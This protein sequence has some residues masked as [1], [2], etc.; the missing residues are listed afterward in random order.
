MRGRERR[1]GIGA[2]GFGWDRLI[3]FFRSRRGR[4]QISRDG[5]LPPFVIS[6]VVLLLLL[7]CLYSLLRLLFFRSLNGSGLSVPCCLVSLISRRRRMICVLV[8]FVLFP[9]VI[10]SAHLCRSLGHR[11]FPIYH[12]LPHINYCL[13]GVESRE[14]ARPGCQGIHLNKN[15]RET[16]SICH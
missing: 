7:L 16:S 10:W 2:R 11:F 14:A 9:I 6:R 13:S 5:F 12:C 4:R 15:A 3:L 1:L 8:I